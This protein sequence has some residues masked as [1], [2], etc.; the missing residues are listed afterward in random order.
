MTK[1]RKKLTVKQRKFVEAYEGNASEA[2]RIAG[3]SPKTAFRMGQE[4]M[5]KPAILQALQ[6]REEKEGSPHI[7]TRQA[8][9]E[10]WSKVILGEV[11]DKVVD[12]RTGE[13]IEQ[14]LTMRDRLK[15]SELLGRS[16]GDFV[17]RQEQA[18]NSRL[19]VIRKIIDPAV[20]Q[21]E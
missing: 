19:V 3:Y 17:E 13:L 9:Q 12:R 16:N 18:I 10:F 4:N 8:R 7:L 14:P 21:E 15:A 2:A 6:E 20:S 5:Q 11:T 1:Q